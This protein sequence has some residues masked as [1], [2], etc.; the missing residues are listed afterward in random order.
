MFRLISATPSPYARKVRIALAEKGLPFEL[1]TEVPWDSTTT[2]PE[3]NP[4]EKLPIL[5][6]EDGTSVYDSRFI[7]QY[8][9]VKHPHPSLLPDDEDAALTARKLEVLCDGVCDALVLTFF[10]R[11][12]DEGGSP[13]WIA[14]QRRKIDGGLREIARIVGNRQWAVGERFSLGDIAAGTA[15]GYLSVRLPELDWRT[16]YPDLAALSDRLE[17]RCS[18]RESVPYAQPISDKVV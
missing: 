15:V 1:I 17:E 18:F 4:L 10:E 16:L 3:F 11:M 14:R 6:L 13:E 7:L 8:L 2:T 9:E 5:L 12:R